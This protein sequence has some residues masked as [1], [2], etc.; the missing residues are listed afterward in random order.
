M[1]CERSPQPKLCYR[2]VLALLPTVCSR[3]CFPAHTRQ[4]FSSTK[5]LVGKSFFHLLV[6]F[7]FYIKAPQTQLDVGTSNTIAKNNGSYFALIPPF[8]NPLPFAL[9]SASL[10]H[11]PLLGLSL[12]SIFHGVAGNDILDAATPQKKTQGA[13]SQHLGCQHHFTLPMKGNNLKTPRLVISSAWPENVTETSF[14]FL[15]NMFLRES[16][17]A[18]KSSATTD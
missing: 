11:V 4:L 12:C 1:C 15:C 18:L 2:T 9:I 13:E 6:R 5:V 10:R 17:R 3:P 16:T 8:P 7:I 14:P